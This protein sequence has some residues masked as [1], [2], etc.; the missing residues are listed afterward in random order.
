M[1]RHRIYPDDHLATATQGSDHV[2]FVVFRR[3]ISEYQDAGFTTHPH[4]AWLDQH[5]T[6]VQITPFNDL[7]V[8]EYRSSPTP[9]AGAR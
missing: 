8:Y 6:L 7:D 4:L 2:W 3:A 1:T 9:A 5:Y